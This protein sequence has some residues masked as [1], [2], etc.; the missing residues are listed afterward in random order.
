MSAGR[1]SGVGQRFTPEPFPRCPNGTFRPYRWADDRVEPGLRWLIWQCDQCGLGGFQIVDDGQR[2]RPR[3]RERERKRHLTVVPPTPPRR[4][5]SQLRYRRSIPSAEYVPLLSGRDVYRGGWS[6]ARG[7]RTARSG[8]RAC[9]SVT[10]TAA[11]IAT[12]ARCVRHLRVLRLPD[13]PR[14]ARRW[15]RVRPADRR[16]RCRVA[17]GD[18]KPEEFA[19]VDLFPP[20]WDSVVEIPD[21]DAFFNGKTFV[22]SYLGERLRKLHPLPPAAGSCTCSGTASTAPPRSFSDSRS[23]HGS[24]RNGA[25]RG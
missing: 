9:M 22:P 7:T 24:G 12:A 19:D 23:Q 11:G 8:R 4:D 5:G 2:D 17:E 16:G 20:G 3:V 25:L 6:G 10:T 21:A 14:A 15:P 1:R 13:R 18:V